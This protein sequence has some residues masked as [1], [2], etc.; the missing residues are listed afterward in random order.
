MERIDAHQHFW[1]FDPVRD[2]WITEGQ[3]SVIRKD[4]LP[5]DLFPILKSNNI[6]G[7]V[8]VQSN[9]AEEDTLFLLNLARENVFIKGVVGWIDLSADNIEACLKNYRLHKMLKGFRHV[10]QGEKDERFMLRPEFK[11]GISL[12]NKYDFT[13][14]ILIY[15]NHLK[16]AELLVAEFPD[17]RFVID[18]LAKPDIKNKKIDRWKMD[19]ETI[20][21]Y[22]NVSCKISGMVTEADWNLWD[23]K[24]FNPYLDIVFNAFG[25]NRVM[26]GSDW[27]VCNLAGGYDKSLEIFSD[28]TSKLSQHEQSLLW[29]GNAIKFYNL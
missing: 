6:N 4:F 14:D 16:Y 26:Y 7:C 1:K 21:K 5:E 23:K 2:S 10:L 12:L 20:S 28:Y 25:I 15:P 9:Q 13:Y 17:Q 8:A 3:M 29:G 24:D 18:H 11:R 19:M 22:Q 27:P